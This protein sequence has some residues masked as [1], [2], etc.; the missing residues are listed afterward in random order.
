MNLINFGALGISDAFLD[1]FLPVLVDIVNLV[2]SIAIVWAVLYLARRQVSEFVDRLKWASLSLI[3]IRC[4]RAY[5]G[6]VNGIGYKV[7]NQLNHSI[8]KSSGTGAKTKKVSML[9]NHID[10]DTVNQMVHEVYKFFC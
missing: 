6:F 1:A 9:I 8:Q 10:H 5:I 7:S 2:G 3:A 4:V